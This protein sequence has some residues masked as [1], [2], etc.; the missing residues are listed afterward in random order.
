MAVTA[1]LPHKVFGQRCKPPFFLQKSLVSRLFLL[2]L[3][4]AFEC[5]RAV[6]YGYAYAY[7]AELL[8]LSISI[9]SQCVTLVLSKKR[10]QHYKPIHYVMKKNLM[11]AALLGLLVVAAPACTF[12]SCKDYDDD[13]NKVNNRLDGLEAAKTQINT[14]ITSLKSDLQKANEKATQLEAKLAEYATKTELQNG[15][16]A[17]ADKKELET[18][19]NNLSAKIAEVAKLETRIQALETAKAE[20]T[21][22]VNAKVD[23]KTY[24]AKVADIEGRL[25][26]AQ[27]KATLAADKANTL[28]QTLNT[29][30]NKVDNQLVAL[31]K[32]NEK[33]AAL[34]GKDADLQKKLDE[35]KNTVT[36]KVAE[37]KK[38]VKAL[39]DA[40]YQTA[41][42]VD[43]KVNPVAERVGKL[44]TA[45][46]MLRVAKVTSLVLQP[47][48]FEG[49]I[50]GII[51]TDYVYKA[52]EKLDEANEKGVVEFKT[53]GEAAGNDLVKN[54]ALAT[55][56][57]NPS[58]AKVDK[59]KENFAFVSLRPTTRTSGSEDVT[60]SSVDFDTAKG[61]L[62]VGFH[63]S[64]PAEGP[65]EDGNDE[66]NVVALS[67][68]EK[69]GTTARTVV[70]DY[71]RV[72]AA[73]YSKL[74]IGKASDDEVLAPEFLKK[75]GKDNLKELAATEKEKRTFTVLN[76]GTPAKLAEQV[77]S[78]G[79]NAGERSFI[80][81]NAA[82]NSLLKEAGFEYKYALVK[83]GADDKSTD[84]FTIDPKTGELKVE[85]DAEKPFQYVGKM[86]VVRVTLVDANGKVASVGYF[87]ARVS[88]PAKVVANLVVNDELKVVCDKN[89]V[90]PELSVDLEPLTKYLAKN[91]GMAEADVWKNGLNNNFTIKTPGNVHEQ[92]TVKDGVATGVPVVERLG[93]LLR[94]ITPE[95]KNIITWSGLTE[96]KVANL[97]K[98]G[99]SVSVILQVIKRD[100]PE[101]VVLYFEVKWAP[102]SIQAQPEVAFTGKPVANWWY[103]NQNVAAEQEQRMHVSIDGQNTFSHDL[104]KGFLPGSVIAP[105]LDATKYP[106]DIKTT[107]SAWKF[108]EPRVKQAK[109]T[110]GKAYNLSVSADGTSF[111]AQEMKGGKPD[112]LAKITSAGVIT[113]QNNPVSKALLNY[114][115]YNELKDGQTLTARVAYVTTA[116]AGKKVLKATDATKKYAEFDVKFI[117]PLNVNYTGRVAFDDANKAKQEAEINFEGAITDWRQVAKLS[118]LKAA[119]GAL[120]VGFAPESEWTTNLNGVDIE[121]VKLKD[122]FGSTFGVSVAADP[123][124]TEVTTGEFTGYKEYAFGTYPKLQYVTNTANLKQFT[125]RIPVYVKY[126]WGEIKSH[127]DVQVG[128]TLNQGNAR[129]K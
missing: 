125:I 31:D 119:Y 32:F 2:N 101:H 52:L 1:F 66:I 104:T 49:G 29:L 126:H 90:H 34:E 83:D 99:E 22:L 46:D 105:A 12:V 60:V 94:S 80:D 10:Y 33:V 84:G 48:H 86:A 35:L 13:F 47:N 85:F 82:Q 50:E 28:E 3:H 58:S 70:S 15:L 11:N 127:I 129:R 73:K 61:E 54:F 116:C 106:T 81:D 43:A 19:V 24:D 36:E 7:A 118:D 63:N 97:R 96:E 69:D 21:A 124:G 102:R 115:G 120:S 62:Y 67:Y 4:R 107:A 17:K 6:P 113:Y 9:K 79:E 77:R 98:A 8:S 25:T 89:S 16:A 18:A 72:V 91:F 108:V 123:A 112:T 111:L 44:E 53:E 65:N 42:Q 5:S 55:Y 51:S 93:K 68:T 71:A 40:G 38:D 64:L 87:Y 20:L 41:A 100:Q 37:L 92:F 76:D 23:Q 117:R 75:A 109:G 88:A 110:D 56:H 14:E 74:R 122:T 121:T 114:A 45:L 128:K 59:N 57:V 95:G 26:A 30:K 27:S 103:Q 78:Y 39:Q